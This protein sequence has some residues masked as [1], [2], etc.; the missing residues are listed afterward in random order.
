ISRDFVSYN[1]HIIR[2]LPRPQ[3]L[4]LTNSSPFPCPKP[5]S[6]MAQSM[7]KIVLLAITVSTLACSTQAAEC[8]PQ[9]VGRQTYCCLNASNTPKGYQGT[10]CTL[11]PCS[12]GGCD[13]KPGGRCT[14]CCNYFQLNGN[15][16]YSCESP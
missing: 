13:R 9:S 8:G 12:G 3:S 14:L 6:I 2:P 4:I 1:Q 5:S 15:V 11:G 16:A 10:D 7:L